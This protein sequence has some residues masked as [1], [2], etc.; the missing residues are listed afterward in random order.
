M[1]DA[2]EAFQLTMI[3]VWEKFDDYDSFRNFKPWALGIAK[4]KA[5]GLMRDRQ[6]ERLVFGGDLVAR[7]ADETTASESRYL[8]RQEALNPRRLPA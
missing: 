8:N 6:R 4:Y 1:A 2:D 3:T 7:L 5:L